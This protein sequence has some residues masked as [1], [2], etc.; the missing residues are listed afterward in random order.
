M[1]T[2]FTKRSKEKMRQEKLSAMARDQQQ[3]K[4]CP[5]KRFGSDFGARSR[6]GGM[7]SGPQPLELK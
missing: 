4:L 7:I 6:P 5:Q 1:T 2:T 3:R